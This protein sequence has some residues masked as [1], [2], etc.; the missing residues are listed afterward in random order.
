MEVSFLHSTEILQYANRQG[1]FEKLVRQLIKDFG[2]AN[3]EPGFKEDVS[4]GALEKLL[5]EKLY[6]LILEHFADYINLLYVIDV[7]EKSFKD[8]AITDAVEVAKQVSFLVLKREFQKVW[9]KNKY[10]S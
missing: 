2:L 9:Y 1:L 10:A 5:T 6:V 3:I 4:L 8:V 7:P